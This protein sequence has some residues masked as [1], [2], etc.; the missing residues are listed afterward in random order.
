MKRVLLI[1]ALAA[2]LVAPALAQ[3]PAWDNLRVLGQTPPL[4]DETGATITLAGLRTKYDEAVVGMSLVKDGTEVRF[5][6]NAKTWDT[7][8]QFLIMARDQWQTL[9]PDQFTPVGSVKGYKIANRLATLSISLQGATTLSKKRLMLA[10]SGGADKPK[11]AVV[12]MKEENL[13]DLV[14]AL[15]KVDEY[16]RKP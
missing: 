11:R 6:M 16:L 2:S 7:L 14:E 9:N 10:A 3:S 13:D 15:Y 1:V 5:Y 8:K 4:T 12:A